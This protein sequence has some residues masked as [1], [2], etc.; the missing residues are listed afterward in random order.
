MY[1]CELPV[2]VL[3]LSQMGSPERLG[4]SG[5]V[6]T[7]CRHNHYLVRSWL[8]ELEEASSGAWGSVSC[9]SSEFVVVG[10]VIDPTAISSVTD[11][12]D[13]NEIVAIY[14]TENLTRVVIQMDNEIHQSISSCAETIQHIQMDAALTQERLGLL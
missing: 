6:S 10:E 3:M 14:T 5:R 12:M 4:Q 11:S 8:I 7:D 9:N 13:G 1:D 2:I